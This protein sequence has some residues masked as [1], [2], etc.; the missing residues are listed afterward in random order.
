MISRLKYESTKNTTS[1]SCIY[2]ISYYICSQIHIGVY[3]R[4]G[5][6]V[7]KSCKLSISLHKATVD[8]YVGMIV[9]TPIIGCG[10]FILAWVWR[11][12]FG[13]MGMQEPQYVD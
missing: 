3:K 11:C 2:Q 5:G 10:V 4:F 6:N 7:L 12:L 9:H 8:D 13:G 1:Y